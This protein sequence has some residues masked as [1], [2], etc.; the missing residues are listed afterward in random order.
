MRTKAERLADFLESLPIDIDFA[1]HV[2]CDEVESVD[3]IRDQLEDG[4]AFDVEII[5]Y[6]RAIEYLWENDPSLQESLELAS[7][8]GYECSSLNSEALA[9]LLAS[10]KIRDEW[11][12]LES[13]IEDF[14]EELNEEED[15]EE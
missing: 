9:S 3:D 15:E 11:Y 8:M 4:G 2:D 5:Y 7:E 10:Q 14:I 13:E 12:K 6:A 1:Y